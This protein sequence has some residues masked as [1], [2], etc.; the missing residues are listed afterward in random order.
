[1]KGERLD[2]EY[3]WLCPG[4]KHLGRGKKKKRLK[5]FSRLQIW[6]VSSIS[7]RYGINFSWNEL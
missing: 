6:F 5:F 4:L 7:K 1:M 3:L 2:T